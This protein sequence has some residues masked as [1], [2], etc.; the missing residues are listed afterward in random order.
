MGSQLIVIYKQPI[1]TERKTL[2]KSLE[3]KVLKLFRITLFEYIL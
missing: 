1:L 3:F 2:E